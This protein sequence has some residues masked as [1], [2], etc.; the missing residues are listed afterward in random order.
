MG[1]GS[2]VEVQIELIS[3]V[4]IRAPVA[5]VTYVRKRKRK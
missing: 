4:C 1:D 5:L 3:N 2:E